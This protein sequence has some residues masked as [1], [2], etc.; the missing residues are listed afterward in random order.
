M[1][2]ALASGKTV[3]CF[4]LTEPDFGSDLAGMTT[5]AKDMGDHF[6][7]NGEKAWITN[8]PIADVL[9]VWAKDDN[10]RVRGLVL[11]RE[12]AGIETP[13]HEGKF[14]LRCSVTG[15]IIMNNVRVPKD[16][17]L[18]VVGFKG[19]FFCL[20]N[21]RFGISWGTL[22]TAEFC[23]HTAR[24]YTMERKQ[25]GKPLAQTQLI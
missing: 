16:H 9:L 1:I 17:V 13:V 22:G 11:R 18:D 3:G 2:P 14:S 8:S 7:V 25:F 24:E 15:R 21:A 19:P 5:T 4:G 23:F 20:N 6:V 10:G 12:F